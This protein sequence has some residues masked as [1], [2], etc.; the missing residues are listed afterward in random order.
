[1]GLVVSHGVPPDTSEV[2]RGVEGDGAALAGAAVVA[3]LRGGGR[4]QS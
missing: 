1:M 4:K 3:G 2:L